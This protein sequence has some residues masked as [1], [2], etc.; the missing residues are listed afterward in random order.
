MGLSVH[1]LTSG[2]LV[3]VVVFFISTG[4]FF[5]AAYSKVNQ[6]L[7]K[8]DSK[9]NNL[10]QLESVLNSLRVAYV[11]AFIAAGLTLLLAVLYAG[12]ETIITPSEYWHLALYLIT[13]A[14]LVISTIYAF[15]ALNKLYDV[16]ISD[17]NG[18]DS[19][20]WAGY[21]TS[22]FAFM[23]LTATGSGR[24][25]MNAVRHKAKQRIEA[26]EN[27]IH[28]HLPAIRDKVEDVKSSVDTHLSMAHA[29]IDD[30]HQMSMANMSMSNMEGEVL[31][32]E[33]VPAE[34]VRR[35]VIPTEVV[36]TSVTP[37]QVVRT[38]TLLPAY[39]V[40]NIPVSTPTL[41]R[42]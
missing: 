3:S 32:R 36:R 21:L 8:G 17:R 40:P 34:V 38:E 39:G 1:I 6:V 20:I 10:N 5:A 23:G 29:K 12:H 2:F 35:E 26:V 11:L 33:F 42:V 9:A 28:E 30:L 31:R 7:Q 14:L 25:G 19:Y 22:L 15:I 16:R 37:R 27:T 4:Y 41:R 18:A 13:Y 24:L